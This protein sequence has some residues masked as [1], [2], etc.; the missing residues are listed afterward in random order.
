MTFVSPGTPVPCCVDV[1]DGYVPRARYALRMLLLP[2]GLEPQW[3]EP[4]PESLYYGP[5]PTGH[6]GRTL[7]YAPEA[8]SFYA[9]GEAFRPAEATWRRLADEDVPV[10]FTD[11][12]G[13]P[14]LVAS[15]FL[16]LSG[17]QERTAGL[18]DEHGRVPYAGS[19]N[20]VLG[21]ARRPVVDAYRA[22][23]AGQLRRTGLEPRVRRWGGRPWAFCPTHDVDYLRKWRP[24]ILYRELVEY[25][26]L[27]RRDVPPSRRIARARKACRQMIGRDPYLR[28]LHEMPLDVS[29]R[30]GTATYFVKTGSGDPHDVPYRI[31]S[32]LL[33]NWMG[34]LREGG[35]EIGLHPSYAALERL[36]RF[37]EEKERLERAAGASVAAVRH[38][39][40]RYDP[41]RTGPMQQEL[42]FRIDSTLGYAEHEGFRRGTCMPF[43][44]YDLERDLPLDVWEMPLALMDSTLFNR[45]RL[46]AAQA[47]E[48][49]GELAEACQKYGGV[50]VGLWHTTLGDE[51]DCP[52]WRTHFL[53]ALD[54]ARQGEAVIASLSDALR[55]WA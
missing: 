42:G 10:C 7:A 25:L 18:R 39:Y 19:L 15:A 17:W 41:L 29:D 37:R 54:T 46:R 35:F 53:H 36:D 45:R 23:L 6:A 20:A 38:H 24:G 12:A 55:A 40:L 9:R 4:S 34:R 28:A 33:R 8:S 3:V 32:T 51:I 14:D 5:R 1:R 48:V 26:M 2:L 16:W 30:G 22:S 43:Q 13:R 27:N 50:L 11:Q 31:G 47:A 21:T 44:V 49:T 52:G